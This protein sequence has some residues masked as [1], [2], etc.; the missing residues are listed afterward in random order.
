MIVGKAT[1]TVSGGKEETIYKATGEEYAVTPPQTIEVDGLT[2][3]LKKIV[4][5]SEKWHSS[6]VEKGLVKEGIPTIVYQY[7]LQLMKAP[8]VETPEYIGGAVAIDPPTVEVPEYEGGAVAKDPP[9]V[10]IPEYD[11]PKE[12][13]PTPET[14]PDSIIVSNTPEKEYAP[15]ASELIQV[16][17]LAN[18]GTTE[19]N[20][21][22]AGLGLGILGAFLAA[23]RRR[24]EK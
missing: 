2:F 1:T 19:T 6:T 3:E 23:A 15:K 13:N 17:H 11:L 5:V 12:L 4:P 7:V 8:E 16:K 21:G 9:V 24:K 18:T 20:T 14:K 22:L 10:E